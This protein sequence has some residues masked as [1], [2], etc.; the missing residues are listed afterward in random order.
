M[1]YEMRVYDAAPGKTGALV[2]RFGEH[3]VRLF[4]KHG[5]G[6]VGFWTTEIGT[7]G[8]LTYTLS[9]DSV[10]AREKSW[11]GFEVDAEWQQVLHEERE[12]EGFLVEGVRNSILKPTPYSPEPRIRSDVQELRT[13]EAM[14]G[15]MP[16]LHARFRDHTT[17][18]FRQHGM[19]VIGYW[20]ED[21]GTGNMLVYMVGY[22]SLGD[23][24]KSWATFM[25]D[26]AWQKALADSQR[27]GSLTRRS[28]NYILRPTSFC[29]RG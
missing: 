24:E 23:R 9:F 20:T 18:L 13:Y 15:K 22:P 26:P 25:A 7:G 10:S 16:N 11:A 4:A 1:I 3:N 5:M 21:V 12:R 27:D 28:W 19:D 17:A 6:M 29:P 8:Q 2:R 14:P